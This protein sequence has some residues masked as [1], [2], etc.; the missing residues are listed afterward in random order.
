MAVQPNFYGTRM[1]MVVEG[2]N[3]RGSDFSTI[4]NPS[5]EITDMASTTTGGTLAVLIDASATF[6]TDFKNNKIAI[7]DTVRIPSDN[8]YTTIKSIDSETQI[9]LNE[10]LFPA[11]F[12]ATDYQIYKPNDRG[13]LLYCTANTSNPVLNVVTVGGDEV[14]V[15][16]LG[17]TQNLL[18]FQVLSLKQTGTVTGSPHSLVAIF[19]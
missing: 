4:P 17:R 19:P 12:A 13:C 7:G 18:P 1:I 9:T 3:G 16:T 10:S 14:K 8:K 5:L 11:V 2:A 6:E 15:T